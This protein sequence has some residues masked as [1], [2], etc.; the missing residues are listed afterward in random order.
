MDGSIR[1]K[2][3]GLLLGLFFLASI[4]GCSSAPWNK[5]R[6]PASLRVAPD[7]IDTNAEKI[8]AHGSSFTPGSQVSVGFPDVSVH[9]DLPFAKGMWTNVVVAD[10]SG[11]FAAEIDLGG[12]LWRLGRVVG[13]K[14]IPGTYKVMARNKEGDVATCT[15]VV[16]EGER[17]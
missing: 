9:K 1:L 2:G 15:L 4:V 16:T 8:A 5:A 11:V 13:A 14:N 3:I 6:E 17:K 7:V 10:Q 12:T